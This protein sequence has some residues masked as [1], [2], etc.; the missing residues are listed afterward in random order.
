M[1]SNTFGI[2]GKDAAAWLAAQGISLPAQPNTR[3]ICGENRILRLG[4]FEYMVEGPAADALRLAWENQP[5]RGAFLVPRYD[6]VFALDNTRGR[7]ALMEICAMDTAPEVI[8][9]AVLM[10]LA[11]GISITLVFEQNL[12][13]LWCDATYGDYMQQ[14]LQELTD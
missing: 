6:A 3:S 8:G 10:T 5:G 7:N 4:R 14:V 12:Y 9:D 2:K 1:I 13:R 11:A